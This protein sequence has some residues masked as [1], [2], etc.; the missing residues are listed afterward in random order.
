[1]FKNNEE[2]RHDEITRSA[3]MEMKFISYYPPDT[4]ATRSGCPGG[5]A[6]VKQFTFFLLKDYLLKGT[7]FQYIQGRIEIR[8]GRFW[9]E[10]KS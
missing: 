1:M 6:A 2:P 3:R 8:C 10:S 7:E 9:T 5:K 4:L